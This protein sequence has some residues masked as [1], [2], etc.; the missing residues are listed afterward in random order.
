MSKRDAQKSHFRRR[1]FERYSLQINEGEYDFLVSRIRKNDKAVV[2]FLTKQS[3]RLSVHLI[4]Y[5]NTE[6]VAVYDKLR[7]SLVT[8]L[9]P[10]CKDITQIMSYIDELG[11]E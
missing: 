1:V 8:A 5:R 2:T 4:N 6:F 7:K 3:N 9:P 10:I 11:D